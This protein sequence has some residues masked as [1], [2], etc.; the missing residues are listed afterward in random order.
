M[1]RSKGSKTFYPAAANSRPG[2][3]APS[4]MPLTRKDW[5]KQQTSSPPEARTWCQEI[6]PSTAVLLVVLGLGLAARNLYVEISKPAPPTLSHEEMVKREK[7]GEFEEAKW[8]AEAAEV[9]LI[10][11]KKAASDAGAFEASGADPQRR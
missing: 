3:V 4:L 2:Q 8:E 5:R 6:L 1:G 9:R 7:L 10:K 11:A